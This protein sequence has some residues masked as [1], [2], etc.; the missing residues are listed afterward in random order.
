M[1]SKEVAE[2]AKRREADIKELLTSK[3]YY[4]GRPILGK[5]GDFNIIWGMRSNGKT[6]FALKY[7]L[8]NYKKAKRT[9]VYCRRWAEDIV[10]KNMSKLMSPLPVVCMVSKP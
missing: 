9:F 2:R 1:A 4:D 5:N 3:D 6:Y 7:A 8:E 10:V